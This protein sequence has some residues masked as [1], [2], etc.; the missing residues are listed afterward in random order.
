MAIL[1]VSRVGRKRRPFR[2]GD[3]VTYWVNQQVVAG[4]I[5]SC[6][7]FPKSRR[8]FAGLAVPGRQG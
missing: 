8:G 4:A 3:I 7:D 5:I 2:R 6:N 1:H